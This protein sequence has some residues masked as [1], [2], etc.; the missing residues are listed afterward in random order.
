MN[1]QMKQTRKRRKDQDSHKSSVVM[2]KSQSV[3]ISSASQ[4]VVVIEAADLSIFNSDLFS[5]GSDTLKN[6]ILL[7]AP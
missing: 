7:N 1:E 3:S 6:L 4:A 5:D 2:G